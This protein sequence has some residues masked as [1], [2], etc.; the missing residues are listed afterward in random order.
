VQEGH[1]TR[2]EERDLRLLASGKCI[3]EIAATTGCSY[4]TTQARLARVRIRLGLRHTVALVRYA[5]LR[6]S[7]GEEP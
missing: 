5:V 4:E 3:S 1:A 7:T 2:A 6:Y